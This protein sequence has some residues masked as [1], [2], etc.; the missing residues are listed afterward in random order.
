MLV[1]VIPYCGLVGRRSLLVGAAGLALVLA[2]A[3][4]IHWKASRRGLGRRP[5]GVRGAGD[6][7]AVVV[8]GFRN[9]GR[10]ANY[11]NR[12]RVRAGL[13]SFSATAR[14]S[15]LVLCGGAVGGPEA[16]ADLMARY[17]RDDLGYVGPV[18]LDRHS[19]STWENIQH[20]I[21]LIEGAE[22][23]KIVSNSL[24]AEKGRAYL[25]TLRPDLADRLQRGADYRLGE[26]LGLKVVAGV[27][28]QRQRFRGCRRAIR[29]LPR[30]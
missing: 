16:E 21:P 3:E 27:L 10:R 2:W 17:A 18:Q 30:R 22:T 23:I 12:F 5:A 28:A 6:V 19:R 1:V 8:L 20:A 14:E 24:H 11:V 7:D 25:R 29:S 13:R 4:V 15:V 9:R 26:A